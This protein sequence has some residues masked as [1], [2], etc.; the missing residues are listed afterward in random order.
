MEFNQVT[1]AAIA[2]IIIG[3]W[4]LIKSSKQRTTDGEWGSNLQW[5]YLLVMIGVFGVLSVGLAWSFTAVLLVFTLFTGAVWTWA[6]LS[7]Q[8][9]NLLDNN[10]FRDYTA[11]FFPI[12]A[13]VFVLRTFVAEP[14]QIPSSSM[15]PG[16]IKGDF[17]LVNKFIYGIRVPVLNSVLI[18]TGQVQ[19][20]DVAVFNFPMDTRVNY[21]KRIVGVPGDIIEYKDKILTINGITEHDKPIGQYLYLD[22]NDGRQMQTAERFQ[23]AFG[24][25]QFDVLKVNHAP[26]VDPLTFNSYQKRLDMLQHKSG[27]AENCEYA[28]NGSSF[29]CHVPQGKYFAMGDNRDNSADSR[30]W[31]FVDDQQ[32]VGKAFFIW[33]NLGDMK[34]IGNSIQ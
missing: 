7:H 14:F 21:I 33:M 25:R 23:A 10:H 20:G 6:K 17:I 2:S 15:R 30:Y 31:G 5:G 27:L 32:V 24:G 28:E 26:S 34:R 11:G 8:D 4:L 18:S 19:R 9:K 13:V 29:K 3:T 12:I 16:L 1:Y 22:D